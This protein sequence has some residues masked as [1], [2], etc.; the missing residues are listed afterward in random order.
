ME[1]P[2][3]LLEVRVNTEAGGGYVSKSRMISLPHHTYSKS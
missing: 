3:L 1:P 2:I